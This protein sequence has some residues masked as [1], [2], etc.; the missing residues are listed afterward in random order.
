MPYLIAYEESVA[1]QLETN[2]LVVV[3][4]EEITQLF[5]AR[6]VLTRISSF[7]ALLQQLSRGGGN[8]DRVE[9]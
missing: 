4:K 6:E 5:K 7:N 1:E 8:S 2:E 3:H 9:L